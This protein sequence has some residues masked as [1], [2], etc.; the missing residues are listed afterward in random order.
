MLKKHLHY[1]S[2]RSS[3]HIANGF[4]AISVSLNCNSCLFVGIHCINVTARGFSW[5]LGWLKMFNSTFEFNNWEKLVHEILLK[6]LIMLIIW[7]SETKGSTMRIYKTIFQIWLCKNLCSYSKSRKI[8]IFTISTLL[9]I[10]TCEKC[11]WSVRFLKQ[12]NE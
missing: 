5:V 11:H 2:L 1:I 7:M 6:S 3:L 10:T 8:I 9:Q 12:K 4:A